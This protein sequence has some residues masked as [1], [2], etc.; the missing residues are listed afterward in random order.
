MSTS[1]EQPTPNEQATPHF[2]TNIQGDV[3]QLI[4]IA[5]VQGSVNLFSQAVIDKLLE[6]IAAQGRG[7]DNSLQMREAVAHTLALLRSKN[8]LY[9]DLDHEIW[10][11]VFKS[12]R[13]LRDTLALAS[14]KLHVNGPRNVRSVL[15]LMVEAIRDYVAKYETKYTR[16]M[17]AMPYRR[18][19]EWPELR[20]AGRDLLSLR[21][22]LIA[23]IAP[24]NAYAEEGQAVHW[25]QED[26]W[27]RK[28]ELGRAKSEPFDRTPLQTRDDSTT[29]ALIHALK[30][31]KDWVRW[32]AVDGLS[33]S[34]DPAAVSAL[35]EVLADE[36]GYVRQ[37]AAEALQRIG[38]PAVSALT[39][40]FNKTNSKKE[41]RVAAVYVLREI[42]DPAAISALTTAL[43]DTS[44]D[45]RA[46]AVHALG[47]IGDPA[48]IPAI[49]NALNDADRGV[50]NAASQT[51]RKLQS[52]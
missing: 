29:A 19:R 10:E 11:Y 15:D 23:A 17:Q 34:V 9:A 48:A 2:D 21:E 5:Q 6:A 35:V 44:S 3:Q 30:D 41:L 28:D 31:E 20:Y 38:A 18:E 47:K 36:E 16:F 39:N 1:N 12:L 49:T 32:S 8:A 46:T 26:F 50:R 51:L 24:L 25:D 22:L 45:V 13:E 40:V 37:R 7:V 27:F 4:Q 52:S 42:G 43:N 33:A 14:S